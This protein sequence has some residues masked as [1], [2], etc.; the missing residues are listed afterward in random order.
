MLIDITRLAWRRANARLPTG[1]DRVGLASVARWRDDAR[2]ALVMRGRSA[3][4][5]AADSRAAFDWLLNDQPCSRLAAAQCVARWWLRAQHG[6]AEAGEVLLNLLHR[7]LEHAHYAQDLRRCGVR[8]VFFLHDL[9]P[10]THPE[11]SSPGEPQRH[12]QRVRHAIRLGHGLIV[13]SEATRVGLEAHASALELP[14]PPTVVAPL[15]PGWTA[16]PVRGPRPLAAPHFVVLGTIEPRKNHLLLLCLWRT[17]VQRLGPAA[18]HL[19][20]IGRRGWQCQET[21]NLLDRCESIQPYVH[22]M[23]QCSDASLSNWLQHAQALLFPSFTEGFGMPAVEALVHGLPV[24]ASDLAVLRE[25]VADVPDYA[26]AL[27]GA[28]WLQ[29]IDSYRQ[30]TSPHRRAQ[31]QRLQS[32]SPT[33]WELHHRRIQS[34]LDHLPRVPA[35]QDGGAQVVLG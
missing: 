8:P 22:E 1:V 2:A 34:L 10:L 33:G 26:N 9:I 4:L 30:E 13:N 35:A 25:S 28:R 21:F 15:A 32:F 11:Y 5:G 23:A 20:V 19:V 27:D 12:A 14:L 29:L 7:G 31:L 6:R 3:V 18:P 24:I 17:L 16:A